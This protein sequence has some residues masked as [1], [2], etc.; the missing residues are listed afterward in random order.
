MICIAFLPNCHL[1]TISKSEFY[2][3]NT[4]KMKLFSLL[5]KITPALVSYLCALLFIYAAVSKI[6][7]YENFRVQLAQSPL[8][9]AFAGY[10]AWGVPAF[11]ILISLM[12]LS[13]KWRTVGLFA[14]FGLMV[15]FTAYI[16]IILNFS[17]FIPCS[18]GGV[19]EKMSWNQHLAFNIAF[20][21]LSGAAALIH[22]LVPKTNPS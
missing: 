17:A 7:D 20:V 3:T 2:I 4:D 10:V 9:S 21:L 18:C 5:R 16:Y 12:L 13:E 6:L 22:S 15:M 1:S 19:L 8:L 11:E 14:S